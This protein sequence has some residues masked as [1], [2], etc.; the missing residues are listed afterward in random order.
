MKIKI[1]NYPKNYKNIIF[2]AGR[3]CYGL[4][5]IK[6][7]IKKEDK[8]AFL[9]KIIK[10]QHESVI[11]HCHISVYCR[12]MS[13]SFL[14]QI[15]RHRLCSFSVKSQ[16]YVSHKNFRYK[17]LEDKSMD[18]EYHNLMEIINKF[19]IEAVN[20]G[21]PCY[22]AREALPNSCL[23]NIFMTANI[24]EWRHI[25]KIRCRTDNTPEIRK[26]A[27]H[28]LKLFYNIM[29]ELFDDLVSEYVR[30]H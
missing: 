9:R 1:I 26:W 19:Y 5:I 15:T 22:I 27:H 30:L 25:L 6:K 11:E 10:N 8:S 24:R 2:L 21:M 17:E 4:E 3:N 16:H 13:R 18:K 28:C 23:T 7:D 12:D 14:A 29:P 20:K